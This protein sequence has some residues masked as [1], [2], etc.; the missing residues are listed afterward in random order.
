MT[1]GRRPAALALAG[2]LS[3]A[4]V[5]AGCSHLT[6]SQGSAEP[7]PASASA[8]RSAA[9]IPDCSSWG[10]EPGASA[11]GAAG[12]AVVGEK[13]PEIVLACL[14]GDRPV[15]VRSALS[16]TPHVVNLWASWCRPCRAE[17]PVLSRV[18]AEMSGRVGFLGIDYGEQSGVDGISFAR[19]AG[20]RYPQLEDPDART[21]S[22]WGVTGL[23]V[24]LLVAGD[25][26]VVK[27]LDGAWVSADQLRTAIRTDLER[28]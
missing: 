25:G 13:L 1:R 18:S 24:T 9:G 19:A 11:G 10:P 2:V 5:C 21:R 7:S 12:R 16:G 15:S 17:A 3:V 14:G 26:T 20:W 6:E 27:R 8:A 28:S 4:S 23:P 22:G